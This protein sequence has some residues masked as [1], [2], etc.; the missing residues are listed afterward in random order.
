MPSL[1]EN[2]HW[3]TN[4]FKKGFYDHTI[5]ITVNN[6]KKY[7]RAPYGSYFVMDTTDV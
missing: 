6:W 3:T 4:L 7:L 1:K 5:R 2:W